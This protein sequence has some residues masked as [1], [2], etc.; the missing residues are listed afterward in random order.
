ML[1]N[2]IYD[3]KKRAELGTVKPMVE[4]L[5][6]DRLKDLQQQASQSALI[7]KQCHD[8]LVQ[9]QRDLDMCQTQ[10]KFA[11]RRIEELDQDLQA[12][13]LE[14]QQSKNQLFAISSENQNLKLMISALNNRNKDYAENQAMPMDHH[15]KIIEDYDKRARDLEAKLA[16]AT[17]QKIDLEKAYEENKNARHAKYSANDEDQ[18][19]LID[20]KHNRIKAQ[21]IDHEMESTVKQS[22]P[23]FNAGVNPNKTT[24]AKP[25]KDELEFR[26]QFQVGTTLALKSKEMEVHQLKQE[27]QNIHKDLLEY[28][29]LAIDLKDRNKVLEEDNLNLILANEDLQQ[30]VDGMLENQKVLP[31]SPCDRT[32]S[33]LAGRFSGDEAGAYPRKSNREIVD[34]NEV[35]EQEREYVTDE[36]NQLR[37]M[38]DKESSYSKKLSAQIKDISAKYESLREENYELKQKLKHYESPIMSKNKALSGNELNKGMSDKRSSGAHVHRSKQSSHKLDLKASGEV[39]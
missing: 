33:N 28:R 11:Q 17:L 14:A 10:F 1:K 3:L 16:L 21:P 7:S 27:A 38:V 37:L 22:R 25:T 12:S 5:S 26:G 18:Q 39:K 30:T 23:G 31:S 24:T 20:D 34:R 9:T 8:T 35:L 13:R 19:I 2:A 15:L 29:K 36:M 4:Y 6:A 32:K